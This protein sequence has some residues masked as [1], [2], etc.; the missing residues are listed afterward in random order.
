VQSSPR[1]TTAVGLLYASTVVVWTSY[2][3][4]SVTLP[5]RFEALGLSVVQYGIAVAVFALGMLLTESVW[6]FLAFRIGQVRTILALG[7]IV[8]VL[9]VVIAYATSFV[10]FALALGLFGALVIF[11]VPLFRW[12][13]LIAR[14]PGREGSG[15][16]RYGAYFGGGMVVGSAL[17]PSLYVSLGFGGLMVVVLATYAVGLALMALLPWE[18]TRLPQADPGGTTSVRRVLTTPFLLAA[19]L[20]VFPSSHSRWL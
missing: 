16:G 10:E 4:L 5:F 2:S 18:Q 19:G 14:G 17:G 11:P 15:T 9:Y 13:A 7:L 1:A 3:L 8:M 20:A 12:M 6:G